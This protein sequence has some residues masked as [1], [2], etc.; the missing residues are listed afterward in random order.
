MECPFII[1]KRVYLR[2]LNPDDLEKGYLGWIN[3]PE[4]NRFLMSGIFP[5]SRDKLWGYYE[6]VTNSNNDV[7]F[8]I[9]VKKNDKYIGNIKIGGIDW[10]NRTAHC[11]R[12]IGDKKYRGKGYGTEALKLV[13]DYAFNTLNLNRIYN[14]IVADNMGAIKSCGKVG[15]KREGIFSQA[16]F[17]DGK[18]KDIVQVSITR[19][20]YERLKK[21]K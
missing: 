18:Y 7:I 11:G 2:S 21:E 19:D 8:A 15:M 20:R 14:A 1:G 12:M 3:D 5:T 17:V 6:K 13:I 10:V 9:I 16:R 4:T